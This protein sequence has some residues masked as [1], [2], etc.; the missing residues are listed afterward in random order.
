M[1]PDMKENK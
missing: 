1:S